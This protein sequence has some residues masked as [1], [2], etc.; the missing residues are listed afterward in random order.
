MYNLFEK[1]PV[2]IILLVCLGVFVLE[3]IWMDSRHIVGIAILAVLAYF[4]WQHYYRE[5][6]RFIFWVSIII[7]GS[8]LIDTVFFRIIIGIVLAWF[9]I[10]YL[11]NQSAEKGNVRVVKFSEESI[12]ESDVLYTNK[13]FGQQ[14][15]GTQP[16]QWQDYNSQT[17]IGET[18][19]DLTQTVLPK[20][21][22]LVLVR[23]LAGMIKIIVPYDVEVSIHHSVFIGSVDIFGYGY[24]QMTNRVVHYQT[25]NYQ[26]ANQRVK[27]YTSMIAGKFEVVRG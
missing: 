16:Y 23:H 3:F 21:E 14:K 5:P 8:I 13:W 10:Q 17:I 9:I 22:P 12:Q 6:N 11:Q 26:Q 1:K 2:Q 7:I 27:I 25:E 20:G 4:S 15:R 18:V 24:D 19:I